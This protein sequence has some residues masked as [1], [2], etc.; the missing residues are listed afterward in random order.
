MRGINCNMKLCKAAETLCQRLA[1]Q[2]R[3]FPF[4]RRENFPPNAMQT[5]RSHHGELQSS[6]LFCKIFRL[7][8]NK[9][10]SDFGRGNSASINSSQA[11]HNKRTYDTT[12]LSSRDT[13]DPWLSH[14]AYSGV[15]GNS[16]PKYYH[17]NVK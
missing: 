13:F 8:S 17:A 15:A 9:Q 10:R 7:S 3:I 14:F 16:S 1:H 5:S 2:T 6:Q 11:F 12:Q 4:Q